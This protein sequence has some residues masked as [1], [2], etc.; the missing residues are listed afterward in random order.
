M[1]R[2]NTRRT[3]TEQATEVARKAAQAAAAAVLEAAEADEE[4][5]DEMEESIQPGDDGRPKT[6]KGR[7]MPTAGGPSKDV[8]LGS[9]GPD[10]VSKSRVQEGADDDDKEDDDEMEE[11][12]RN[13]LGRFLNLEADMDD[14]EEDDEDMKEGAADDQLT[15]T[16]DSARADAQRKRQSGTHSGDIGN[17]I[18]DASHPAVPAGT[19]VVEAQMAGEQPSGAEAPNPGSPGDQLTGSDGDTQADA[20]RAGQRGDPGTGGKPSSGALDAAQSAKEKPLDPAA[21]GMDQTVAEATNALFNGED[22]SEDFKTKASTI[23]GAALR[24]VVQRH[25]TN[26]TETYNGYLTEKVAEVQEHY[27]AKHTQLVE[28]IDDYLGYVV[29]QWVSENKLAVETGL[30]ADISDSFMKALHGIFKEHYIE[31]PEDRVDAF[32]ESQ[33]RISELENQLGEQIN[34]NVSLRKELSVKTVDE[35]FAEESDGLADTE[36]ERLRHLCEG[37]VYDDAGQYRQKVQILRENYFGRTAVASSS[38]ADDVDE[39]NTPSAPAL[40]PKMSKY[41]AGM[42]RLAGSASPTGKFPARNLNG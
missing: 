20:K 41:V 9:E 25:A 4:D 22:L 36:R 8:K 27:E 28:R 42:S 38:D 33:T 14:E 30:R 21:V 40:E 17:E 3:R 19:A 23:F 24:E 16:D 34:S 1:A 31:L 18:T 35:V 12:R 26:M 15:R 39:I 11:S 2:S 10:S 37:V 6:Q 7:N 13:P 29:E 32:T 5:D